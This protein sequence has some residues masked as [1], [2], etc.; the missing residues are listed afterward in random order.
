MI[1]VQSRFWNCA[2][3]VPT[4]CLYIYKICIFTICFEPD[5]SFKHVPLSSVVFSESAAIPYL[6]GI[7]IYLDEYGKG[8]DTKLYELCN[9]R[10][11]SMI[12]KNK[13]LFSK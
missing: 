8:C 2:V 10:L 7:N 13:T 6:T 9:E 11:V 3:Y 5:D 1:T 12:E 4:V